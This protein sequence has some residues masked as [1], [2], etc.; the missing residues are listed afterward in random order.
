MSDGRFDAVLRLARRTFGAAK[1]A[2]VL[3]GEP[4]PSEPG[5]VVVAEHAVKTP[6]GIVAGRVVLLDAAPRELDPEQRRALRDLASLVEERLHVV[7]DGELEAALAA[8]RESPRHKAEG[9]AARVL[10]CALIVIMLSV[11]AVSWLM[12][13]RIVAHAEAGPAAIELLRADARFFRWAVGARAGVALCVFF[14]GLAVFERWRE[15][16]LRDRAASRLESARLRSVIDGISDGVVVA[17]AD[18]RLSLFNPAAERI[19]G[20][21][22]V[23]KGPEAWTEVYGVYLEDGVTPCPPD[24]HPLARA[25]AGESCR[26]VTLVVRNEKRP[27]GA[28][29]V[30]SAEPIR[31]AD[32]SI[33]GGVVIF[34]YAA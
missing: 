10:L 14:A 18:G 28:A 32:G 9:R 22:L 25:V 8:L 30:A 20:A 5:L 23:E 6:G 2:V 24:R 21:G 19:L 26:D 4:E 15:S 34:R 1:A 11:T 3:A 33:A 16:A 29:L 13:K 17:A 12:T 7:T 27:G 31:A